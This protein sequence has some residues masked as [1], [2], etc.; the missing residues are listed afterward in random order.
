[1]RK[2]GLANERVRPL[3]SGASREDLMETAA[4]RVSLV[5]LTSTVALMPPSARAQATRP[6][7]ETPNPT[8]IP[9][10]VPG[11]VSLAGSDRPDIAR[12]LNVRTAY[13]PSLAPDGRQLA[14]RTQ[15]SGTPQLWVV[16]AA[17]GWPRQLTFGESVTFHAWSPAGDWIAYGSDRGGNEREGFYLISP[18]GTRE[19]ELLAPSEAFRQ[20]GAFTRDGRHIVYA[21]TERNGVDF[22][23]HL[24]DVASA[25]DRRIFEGR[26]GLYAV[27]FSPDGRHV[28]LTEARGEDA[29][30]VFRLDVAS[31][32]L[33][34][35]FAPPDRSS[36]RS[37][38]W[39][40]D[41]AGF[42]LATDQDRQYAGL[43]H[44]DLA[45]R[46]LRWIETPDR[47]VEDVGLS[48]DGRYLVWTVND[49][50]YS[51]V[52][53]RDL[54]TGTPVSP[55]V[56]PRGLASVTWA[57]GAGVAAFSVTGPQVP[58]DIWLWHPETGETRRAT[59]S[60]AAGLDL[61]RMVVPTHHDFPARDGIT[62]HGLLYMPP[63]LAPGV[64]PPVLLGVHGGP[65][66]QA[67]PDFDAVVQYLLTRGI[68]VFDLN[69]RGSTGYGKAFARLN[70]GRLR[71]R[72]YL[73]LEDAVQWLH[74]LGS[75]DA[76]RA[77]VMGG[78]YGGYLTMAAVTRLPGA[79]RSG[80]A[81]VGVA[82]WVTALEGASP[83]LKASDRIE[84]GDIDDPADR[85]FF[86][87]ISPLTHVRNV[88]VPVMVL[89]GANDPR[90]PVTESDQ[91]VR[92][93]REI[94][95][96]VEY[97]RFPDEGHGIRKLGN[98]IIAYRRIAAFLERTLDAG[99]VP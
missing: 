52:S 67:R 55:P 25:A 94:G 89:H 92:G 13:A 46:R 33:D 59:V 12:F 19:R 66:A 2:R 50:G 54:R 39:A 56:L 6:V 70:D 28:L 20:F 72:E 23:I 75:V 30:D 4:V 17:A 15:I 90:D 82:N 64:R 5:L 97:L 77:A 53:A 99:P 32:R 81:F 3:L 48:F 78:S 49:G 87:E 98:R 62:L 21:T 35:L 22:D 45:T 85:Q 57:E 79:F 47:D 9:G 27:S 61:G 11:E 40:P 8:D 24:I 86:A 10:P 71:A 43:A 42:H 65:T 58:G 44:Y 96:E 7:I 36:Y 95:G 16:D 68:A 63:G 60:D 76:R 31:G 80:V 88:R 69:F 51:T 91:F 37:F 34:T 84:Y 1:M 93:I 14:F 26:M 38:A 18:D 41:G 83:S 73:D 74:T 29:N